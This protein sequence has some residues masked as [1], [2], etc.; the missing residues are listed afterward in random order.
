GF[1]VFA[2]RR[3]VANSSIST[4][5][6]GSVIHSPLGD[7]KVNGH[8]DQAK[9]D[10]VSPFGSVHVNPTPDL[11][12]LDLPVYPGATLVAS[13]QGTPFAE[14]DAQGFDALDGLDNMQFPA[15]AQLGNAPGFQVRLASGGMQMR[16]DG[17][18]FLTPA[19]LD[20]VLAWYQRAFQPFGSVTERERHGKTELE[21]R[22][23]R[24]NVRSVS[25]ESGS[26]GTY[27]M[28]IRAR[29]TNAAK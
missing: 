12:Q 3:F 18:T 29:E 23:S 22:L 19:A 4:S 26:Q 21:V 13:R 28:L 10:I 7:I 16:V 14:N 6:T 24:G 8:G 1:G 17:A 11:A 9:V 20:K 2:I 25:A 5:A 27:F 15:T